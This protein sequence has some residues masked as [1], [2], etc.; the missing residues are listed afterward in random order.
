MI[1][2]VTVFGYTVSER[3]RDFFPGFPREKLKS[4]SRTLHMS[5]ADRL[6]KMSGRY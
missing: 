4:G 5:P 2:I 6:A 1:D 3:E